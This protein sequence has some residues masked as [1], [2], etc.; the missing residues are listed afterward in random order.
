MACAVPTQPSN[1]GGIPE[2]LE[3]GVTG[4]MATAD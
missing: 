2:V 4:F 1:V 3:D